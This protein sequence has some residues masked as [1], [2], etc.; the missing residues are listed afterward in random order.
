M[1]PTVSRRLN[2]PQVRDLGRASLAI[3]SRRRSANPYLSPDHIAEAGPAEGHPIRRHTDNLGTLGSHVVSNLVL[4]KP[5]HVHARTS[6]QPEYLPPAASIRDEDDRWGDGLD[7]S[8][9]SLPKTFRV[10]KGERGARKLEDEDP[11]RRQHA[12]EFGQVP[13]L[14]LR[15]HV[16]EHDVGVDEVETPIVEPLQ[17]RP[18]VQ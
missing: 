6:P 9:E 10:G 4:R 2:R 17:V 13:P 1:T 11:S 14:I 3:C 7:A 16:L 15:L 8:L 12:D 18:V 5:P